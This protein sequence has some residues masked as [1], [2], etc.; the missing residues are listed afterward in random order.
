MQD[1]NIG[2]FSLMK[3]WIQEIGESKNLPQS[4]IENVEG[5]MFMLGSCQLGMPT[6]GA[7]T[8]VCCTKIYWLK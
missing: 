6:K 1:S 2:K 3:E 7:N 8:D 4:V 5:K